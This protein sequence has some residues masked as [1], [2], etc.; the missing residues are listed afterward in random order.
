VAKQNQN[1]EHALVEHPEDP[2]K[3]R[4]TKTNVVP[5]SPPHP[6]SYLLPRS[7]TLS[8]ASQPLPFCLSV[9]YHGQ[10]RTL[11]YP[12]FRRYFN[13]DLYFRTPLSNQALPPCGPLS[14]ARMPPLSPPLAI[15]LVPVHLEP[16]HSYYSDHAPQRAATTRRLRTTGTCLI[17]NARKI[18]CRSA[19]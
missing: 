14:E 15:L 6:L 5:S 10:V 11:P 16:Y 19:L 9:A 8:P 7:P 17:V 1:E 3:K 4:T 18:K 12:S 13:L 2:K